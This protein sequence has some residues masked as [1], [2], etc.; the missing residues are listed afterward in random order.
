MFQRKN[1]SFVL[2]IRATL[3]QEMELRNCELSATIEQLTTKHQQFSEEKFTNEEKLRMQLLMQAKQHSDQLTAADEKVRRLL[4]ARDQEAQRLTR[5]LE[6]SEARRR[7]AEGMLKKINEDIDSANV[8]A[9]RNSA[10]H[11]YR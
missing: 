1:C 10:A 6:E 2:L 9:D 4:D 7:R 8:V 11:Y 5:K 3:A